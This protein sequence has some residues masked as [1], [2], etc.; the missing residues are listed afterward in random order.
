MLMA[1]NDGRIGDGQ[2]RRTVLVRRDR[3]RRIVRVDVLLLM[4]HADRHHHLRRRRRH[5]A[6]GRV[7]GLQ[8]RPRASMDKGRS[9][10]NTTIIIITTTL[11]YSR[12]MKMM[13]MMLLLLRSDVLID[14]LVEPLHLLLRQHRGQ[15]GGVECHERLTIRGACHS[16]RRRFR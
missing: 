9:Y 15:L 11:R 13:M 14:R 1:R 2:V 5:G 10:S 4:E 6:S 3:Q 8:T 16:R 7:H 12:S